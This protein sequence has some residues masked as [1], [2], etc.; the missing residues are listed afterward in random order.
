MI[1][2][3]IVSMALAGCWGVASARFFT[4]DRPVEA[5]MSGCIGGV[6]IAAACMTLFHGLLGLP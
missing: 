4:I 6:V 2:G 1:T 3:T 5:L